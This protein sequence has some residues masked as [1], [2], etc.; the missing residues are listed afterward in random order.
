V[1]AALLW[2]AASMVGASHPADAVRLV[3][4]PLAAIVVAVLALLR[5]RC[6][7]P[8]VVCPRALDR[9]HMRL[10]AAGACT[11]GQR[12]KRESSIVHCKLGSTHVARTQLAVL[13]PTRMPSALQPIA[14]YVLR[15]TP[16]LRSVL[17]PANGS[18]GPWLLPLGFV[19]VT[20][21]DCTIALT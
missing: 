1:H 18:G 10:Q 4:A 7:H 21:R 13:T 2:A 20:V 14:D 5:L 19:R 8:P 11:E 17:P 6:L 16:A 12:E 3:G 15:T 9:M